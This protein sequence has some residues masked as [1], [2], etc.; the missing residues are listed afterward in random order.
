LIKDKINKLNEKEMFKTLEH[1]RFLPNVFVTL[2][3][4]FTLW[5]G[6]FMLGRFV[7]THILKGIVDENLNLLLRRIVTCGFQISIFFTWVRFIE[8]RK[9]F[10]IGFRHNKKLH[11]F[12]TGFFIGITA[13]TIIT[14]ILFLLGTI[15]IEMNKSIDMNMNTYMGITL[16]MLGWLVQSASEE[17]G[18]RGWL[19]PLLG[20]KYSV[21][22]AIF[23]TSIVFGILHLFAPNVTM[24]SFINLILSGLFFALYA[25]SEDCLWGV[26]GCH[27]GWNF[28]LGNIY[29]FS[30]S[31][32]SSI[33]FTI[34]KVKAI[35]SNILTGGS[36]GPEG[37]LLATLVLI[38]G[39]II[40]GIRIKMYFS[41]RTVV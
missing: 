41:R 35:G 40:C 27:F 5:A 19:I 14:I 30:V 36:F 26:W 25:I 39:I 17:I 37:G 8:K 24:L 33:G 16:I 22:V 29:A 7:S 9:I 3:I 1:S 38:M 12:L 13:I 21:S 15:Q 10:T 34:F 18:I 32:F 4:F 11:K 6:S 28:A 20:A 2:F 31:G 23:I